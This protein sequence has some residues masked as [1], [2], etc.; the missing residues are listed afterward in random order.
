M[1]RIERAVANGYVRGVCDPRF[2]EVLEA[3]IENF[4]ARNEA[5]ASVCI[6]LEGATVVDLWGGVRNTDGDPWE[7][8]T[9]CVVFSCTKGASA[10]CAHMAADRGQLDFEAPVARYWPEFARNGKEAALA[11]MMLDH[12]V[13]VPAIRDPLPPGS[14]YDYAYMCDRLAAEAPFWEPG[15]RNGYHGLTSAW[16]VGELVHRAT[17]RRMGGF[18]AEEVAGPLGLDFWIGL[19]ESQDHRVAP[20]IPYPPDEASRRSRIALAVQAD[21]MGPAGRF[22][23]NGGGFNPNSRE[24]RAAEIGSGNGVTNARGLAGL[25]A[26]LANDGAWKGVR[27]A[28]PDAVAR[29][30]AVSVATHQD[31]T[32]HI[33]TRFSLGFMKSM[34]NRRLDN[35]QD[36]SAVLSEAAFG[37][38]G[39]GG[40]IG[41]ADPSEAMSFG[42]AMSRMGAGILLNDRGQSLIDAAYRSLGHR[43]NASGAWRR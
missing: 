26:P 31:A 15:T 40:S 25:Y 22:M 28:S 6:T 41:F 30:G 10:L 27:I 2:T 20:V 17:G 14:V 5:G 29:M 4:D 42:Y 32:L 34:D 39:A 24:G 36:C 12:S 37:H 11:G 1:S 18:L 33:P 16:T 38:V 13:G 35:A 9:L 19:P 21:P 23:L 7:E 8:D 3:F 43:S